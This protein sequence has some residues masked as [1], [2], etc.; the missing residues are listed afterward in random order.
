MIGA[1]S[2]RRPPQRGEDVAKSA[3]SATAH[4][5]PE[6]PETALYGL[7]GD[8]ARALSNTSGA[9]PAGVVLVFL[10]L[11]G[12]AIGQQPH[13]RFG[14][15]DHSARIFGVLVGDAATGGKGTIS[16]GAEALFAEADPDW[17][18][19]RIAF[20]V[21]SPEA[22][23]DRVADDVGDSRL[24]LVETFARLAARIASSGTFG[25]Q[26]RHAYDG[27]PLEIVRSRARKDKATASHAHISLVGHI[28]LSELLGLHGVLRE[29]GGL[30]TRMLFALVARNGEANPF[31][32]PVADHEAP[33][34]TS[35][36]CHRI[37]VCLGDG[38]D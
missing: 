33:D 20:G 26:L 14:V 1:S 2:G 30:E 5:R 24:L 19:H 27:R 11:L 17:Y 12:N 6:L 34:R 15:A 25:A 21:Q 8:V 9:D 38:A 4:L 10:A 3:T 16:A 29:A 23:I 36:S 32:P 18:E 31:A 35:R 7:A 13:V 37:V 28:T 22:L